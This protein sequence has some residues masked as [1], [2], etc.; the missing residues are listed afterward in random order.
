MLSRKMIPALRRSLESIVHYSSTKKDYLG[1]KTSSPTN[2]PSESVNA[3]YAKQ[4]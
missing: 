3:S 2:I 4:R 1:F